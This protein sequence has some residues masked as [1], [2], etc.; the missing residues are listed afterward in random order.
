MKLRVLNVAFPL[1]PVRPDGAGGAEQVLGHIDAALVQAGHRSLVLACEGSVVAGELC[2]IPRAEGKL[3]G[4]HHADL[5]RLVRARI[6]E[7][8]QRERID[9][10]HLHGI[11]FHRYLPKADVPVLVTL[12]MP[13]AWHSDGALLPERRNTFL[14]CVS[15]AQE[16]ACPPEARLLPVIENGVPQDPEPARPR[17]AR[18]R[19]VVSLGRVCP[20]KGLHVACAAAARAGVPIVIAGRVFPFVAHEAYFAEVLSPCL[21]RQAR[22]IGPVGPM[23]KR[24]LLRDAR[25]LLLASTAPETSSLC[26]MEAMAS[27]TPVIAFRAGALPEIVEHGVTGFLVDDEREMAEAIVA[28]EEINPENCQTIARRR[29]SVERMTGEYLQRYA[30]LVANA[31][32]PRTNRA[33]AA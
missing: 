27:G 31:G 12:H 9:V 4:H 7:I 25:A 15:H 16:R 1:A 28:A 13:P 24:R 20:E 33:V 5:Q 29:F 26:A 8:V 18:G 3:T 11:D 17:T 22:F 6:D 32:E 23:R 19:H 30:T 21:G 2:A 10:V 14:H